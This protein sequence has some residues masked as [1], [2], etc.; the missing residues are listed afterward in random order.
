MRALNKFKFAIQNE[1]NRARIIY[2]EILPDLDL[3]NTRAVLSLGGDN[4][5]LDYGKPKFFTDLNNLVLNKNKPILIWG[6]SVG[7]FSKLPD[8]EKY[9][10]EHLKRITGIFARESLT[11]KYLDSLG[12]TR[13]V[14]RVADPA[15]LLDP[16]KP[17]EDKFKEKILDGAIGINFSS[18]MANFL[19]DIS[20]EKWTHNCA[21]IIKKIILE[22]DRPIYLIPH[23]TVQGSSDHAFL[24]KVLSLI[25]R[26][27]DTITL[28][29]ANLNAS[30]TKYIISK[31]YVFL[32]ART[33]SVI[34]ALS[35]GVPTLS[36]TYSIKGIGISRDFYNNDNFSLSKEQLTPDIIVQKTKELIKERENVKEQIEAAL[37]RVEKLALNAGQYLKNII[38]C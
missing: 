28:L 15:F 9:I 16:V 7:P 10:Q 33:H 13:N 3:E 30:E 17:T 22:I 25:G 35:S 11:V 8:Y 12:I 29:S 37:P 26:P 24:M 34:A 4:Y 2:K 1:K 32:G 23:V 36:L 19:T 21:E 27:K 18:L 6:A 5:S 38:A 31:M 14:H 20:L